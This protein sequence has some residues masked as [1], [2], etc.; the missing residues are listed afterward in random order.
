MPVCRAQAVSESIEALADQVV[1]S[2]END[3][4]KTALHALR[5]GMA[6]H[7]HTNT[8]RH[9]HTNQPHSFHFSSH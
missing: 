3:S 2:K 4:L 8:P 9:T 1:T 6:T 7:T 5:N